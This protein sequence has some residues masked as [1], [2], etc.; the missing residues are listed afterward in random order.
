MPELVSFPLR[1]ILRE[2]CVSYLSV[3]VIEDIFYGFGIEAMELDK[4]E[5]EAL[6][7]SRRITVESFYKTFDWTS[8]QGVQLF[9][10]VLTHILDM[11]VQNVGYSIVESDE[12]QHRD[13]QRIL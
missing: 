2:Y 7:S 3:R 13:Q 6:S 8:I 12:K 1:H 11:P 9:L 4:S 5:R 10:Q